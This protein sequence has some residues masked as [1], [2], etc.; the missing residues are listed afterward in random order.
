[1]E[2]YRNNFGAC[3]AGRFCF[4]RVQPDLV[5]AVVC[6]CSF[7]I[8]RH[9]FAD[10]IY[11]NVYVRLRKFCIELVPCIFAQFVV[12]QGNGSYRVRF[13][14]YRISGSQTW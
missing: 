2:C 9:E 11:R 6:V 4:L 12:W 14:N 5:R 7:I 1:M 8:Q 10:L 3:L 13:S